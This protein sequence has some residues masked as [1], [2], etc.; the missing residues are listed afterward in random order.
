MTTEASPGPRRRSG[1]RPRPRDVAVGALALFLV[2][3]VLLAV[4]LASGRDPALA[5]ASATVGT[6]R[7]AV[8]QR[9]PVEPEDS[10]EGDGSSEDEDSGAQS[11]QPAPAPAPAPA[12]LTTRAS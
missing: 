11:H 12:P 7:P 3:F 10:E 6:Q 8:V 9:I 4:Q 2:I 5:P 1:R